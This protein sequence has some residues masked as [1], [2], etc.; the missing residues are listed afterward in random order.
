[1]SNESPDSMQFVLS[2]EAK[3]NTLHEV[4]SEKKP[5]F[6]FPKSQPQPIVEA[7]FDFNMNVDL[8]PKKNSA[9]KKVNIWGNEDE[10]T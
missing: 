1:M 3:I 10:D 8:V 2:P 5:D 6:S 4:N 9:V 7:S